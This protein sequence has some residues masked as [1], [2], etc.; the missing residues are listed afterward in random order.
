M[1]NQYSAQSGGLSRRETTSRSEGLQLTASSKPCVITMVG[2]RARLICAQLSALPLTSG[3][4]GSCAR[5]F[6]LYP[7][8][9]GSTMLAQG[10]PTGFNDCF[11][12]EYAP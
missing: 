11:R 6:Y 2:E 8:L 10:V 7:F 12:K 4:A 5:Q 3:K 9:R 1:Y